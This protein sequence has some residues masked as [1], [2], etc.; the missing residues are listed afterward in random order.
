MSILLVSDIHEDYD[1]LL[2][3]L[4]APSIDACVCCGDLTPA[5]PEDPADAILPKP[6]YSVYGNHE[7]WEYMKR[8][9]PG[10]NW[11]TAGK[12]FRVGC[13]GVAGLGGVM[14]KTPDAPGHFT[15]GEVNLSARIPRGEV[16]IFVSHQPPKY[17]ADLCARDRR[18]CGSPEVLHVM[19]TISPK[20]VFSGHLHWQQID[21]YGKNGGI[22]TCAITLG[23]LSYGDFGIVD[24]KVIRLWQRGL[25]YCDLHWRAA[26]GAG[27]GLRQSAQSAWDKF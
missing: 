2:D 8:P 24:E 11:L 27:E 12:V 7:N 22:D 10:L 21:T 14:S 13:F 26:R 25:H 3:R 20:A 19:K 6:I 5:F 18:H 9:P 15:D 16:D 23:R 17:Y 4:R 1:L